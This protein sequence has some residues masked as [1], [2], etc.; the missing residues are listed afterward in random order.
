MQNFDLGTWRVSL[1]KSETR[2]TQE[3]RF[4]SDL[5]KLNCLNAKGNGCGTIYSAI[6]TGSKEVICNFI[7]QLF[8]GNRKENVQI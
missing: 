8:T 2:R 3:W 1:E 4:S 7:E 6:K 5:N